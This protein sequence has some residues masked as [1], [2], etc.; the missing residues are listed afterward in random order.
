M[1]SLTNQCGY[2]RYNDLYHHSGRLDQAWVYECSAFH[3][4]PQS[5]FDAVHDSHWLLASVAATMKETL[6]LRIEHR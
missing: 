3:G 6:A 4:Y 1:L 2:V 5:E